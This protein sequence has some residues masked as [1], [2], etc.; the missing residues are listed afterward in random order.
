MS[1]GERVSIVGVGTMGTA[2][3]SRLIGRGAR[4]TVWN[5]SPAKCVGLV[6]A[7]ATAAATFEEAIEASPLVISCLIDSQVARSLLSD[8]AVT[9]GLHDTTFVDTSTSSPDDV[10]RLAELLHERGG[11]YLDAKLMFYPAEVGSASATM[12]LA[13]PRDLY[14]RFGNTFANIVGDPR[15][16][17]EDPRHASILYTAVWNYYYS[18][19]FGFLEGLALVIR[20]GLSSSDLLDLALVSSRGL[21]DHLRD[22]TERISENRLDGDQAAVDVYVEGF[23]TMAAAFDDVGIRSRMLESLEALSALA[24]DKGYRRADIAAV[25]KALLDIP[26]S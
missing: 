4:V 11:R 5:R 6:E 25:T 18:G 21:T 1:E 17:G 7:G 3:A 9:R 2:I 8:Q 24:H 13:G 19:L 26:G 10:Q 23:D 16:V 22:A 14:D 12:L 15:F 20:S